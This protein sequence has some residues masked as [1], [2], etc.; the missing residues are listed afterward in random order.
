[1]V[2][3]CFIVSAVPKPLG[4]FV[5]TAPSIDMASLGVTLHCDTGRGI[6]LV[7]LQPR[8]ISVRQSINS[9]NTQKIPKSKVHV[10][11]LTW[12]LK[13]MVSQAGISYS[14]RCHFQVNH[15]KL[16][17]GYLK[18]VQEV[19]DPN[20]PQNMISYSSTRWILKAPKDSK[21]LRSGMSGLGEEMRTQKAHSYMQSFN[22]ICFTFG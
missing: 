12:N 20:V 21:W 15:V 11:K 5:G 13:I 4:F 2:Y 7:A 10:R 16:W 1:M 8:K 18:K 6:A 19:G 9:N 22:D 17:E 3:Y 14:F